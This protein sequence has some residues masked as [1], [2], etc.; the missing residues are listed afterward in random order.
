MKLPGVGFGPRQRCKVVSKQVFTKHAG[1]TK[2]LSVDLRPED[3][4]QRKPPAV[5]V[6]TS[7]SPL[8]PW[9]FSHRRGSFSFQVCH[10]YLGSPL[11]ESQPLFFFRAF[12]KKAFKVQSSICNVTWEEVEGAGST[13]LDTI[14][15]SLF[16]SAVLPRQ[17]SE[18]VVTLRPNRML[19]RREQSSGPATCS[20]LATRQIPIVA[21]K[22]FTIEI[23][24]PRLFRQIVQTRSINIILKIAFHNCRRAINSTSPDRAS[25]YRKAPDGSIKRVR[26]CR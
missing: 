7:S 2:D 11:R 20:S 9:A 3:L 16:E 5:Q 19:L 18:E 14:H 6:W 21:V 12:S 22:G 10:P 13:A 26:P 24:V 4:R 8:F 25:V 15:L 1:S 17:P 23:Q